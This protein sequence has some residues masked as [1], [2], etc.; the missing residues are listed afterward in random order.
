MDA[1]YKINKSKI[2]ITVN[3]I[4]LRKVII[5]FSFFGILFIP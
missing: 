1:K 3:F 5:I 2:K 4:I